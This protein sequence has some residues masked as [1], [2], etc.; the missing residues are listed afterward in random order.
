[1]RSIYLRG[2]RGII[3]GAC[4]PAIYFACLHDFVGFFLY[5][6]LFFHVFEMVGSRKMVR[7]VGEEKIIEKMYN[8]NGITP[9]LLP[10]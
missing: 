5:E 1:M 2:R 8:P 9:G 10:T 4:G 3:G 7:E 6:W